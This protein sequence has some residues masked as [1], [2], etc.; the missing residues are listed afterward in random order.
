MDEGR[1][2]KLETL[3]SISNVKIN[4]NILKIN[5]IYWPP[6]AKTKINWNI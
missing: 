3:T 5:D 1:G 4:T 2:Q 6:R